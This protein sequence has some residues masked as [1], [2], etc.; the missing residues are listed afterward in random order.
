MTDRVNSPYSFEGFVTVI[1]SVDLPS[2]VVVGVNVVGA[3]VV[4][5]VQCRIIEIV[6]KL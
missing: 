4:G 2:T 5:D 1:H 6:T 3:V